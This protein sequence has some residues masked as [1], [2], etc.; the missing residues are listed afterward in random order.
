[1]AVNALRKSSNDDDVISLAKTLIKNW[2]KLL[3]S[4]YANHICTSL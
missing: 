3:G 2:K 4:K 1:M